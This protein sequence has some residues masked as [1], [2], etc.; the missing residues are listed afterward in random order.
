MTDTI[1]TGERKIAP[2]IIARD[3]ANISQ[4]NCGGDLNLKTS[5]IYIYSPEVS[6]ILS[7]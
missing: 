7:V 5:L 3:V 2:R 4:R 1:L 6:F